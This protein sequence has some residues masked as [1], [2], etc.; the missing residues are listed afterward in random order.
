M[1]RIEVPQVELRR[2]NWSRFAVNEFRSKTLYSAA[3]G[4]SKRVLEGRDGR[5]KR[6]RERKEKKR[7]TLDSL[8]LGRRR[9]NANCATTI[10]RYAVAP[11]P[12]CA[13][14]L[15]G[16]RGS[17]SFWKIR[18]RNGP[19]GQ[20][21]INITLVFRCNRDTCDSIFLLVLEWWRA[22]VQLVS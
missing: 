19:A 4:Y 6:K 15:A 12:L 18:G 5:E 7:K 10:N 20:P 3:F 8:S 16:S 9:A 17:A 14:L 22:R 11:A 21:S 2:G 13:Y 1:E